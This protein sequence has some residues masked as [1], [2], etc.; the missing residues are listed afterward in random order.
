VAVGLFCSSVLDFWVAALL[1]FVLAAACRLGRERRLLGKA[2]P[3]GRL[4][5][6]GLAPGASQ[7]RGTAPCWPAALLLVRTGAGGGAHEA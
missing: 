2:G 3:Q 7:R 5:L 1:L 6:Q 4:R